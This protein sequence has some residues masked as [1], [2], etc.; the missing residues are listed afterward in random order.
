MLKNHER[1]CKKIDKVINLELKVQ[2]KSQGF[3]KKVRN[4]Y[5]VLDGGVFLTEFTAQGQINES[6]TL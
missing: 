2:M 1:N 5:K 4:F 3:K 6:F